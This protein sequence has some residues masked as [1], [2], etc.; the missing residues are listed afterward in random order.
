MARYEHLPIYKQALDVAVAYR[1]DAQG[2]ASVARGHDCRDAG[3]RV[4]QEQLPRMP[5]ATE[6]GRAMQEQ[7][8][9]A[10]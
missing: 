8:P 10:W 6:G 3:G 7:L 2:C 9:G 1:D 4:T 5:V